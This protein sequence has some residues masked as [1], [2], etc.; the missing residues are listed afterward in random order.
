[1]LTTFILYNER[2]KVMNIVIEDIP[3]YRIAYIRETGPCGQDNVKTMEQLKYWAKTH[4][5]MK[6]NS[7]ILGIAHDNPEFVLP[8]NCRYDTC[9]VLPHEYGINDEVVKEGVISGGRYAVMAI[10]HTAEAVNEAWQTIF[11]EV[12]KRGYQPDI[13]RPVLERYQAQMVNNHLCELCIAIN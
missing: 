12:L 10:C 9:L 4:D 8:E 11:T 7:I 13:A 1:M 6:D 5:L 3:S 2:I